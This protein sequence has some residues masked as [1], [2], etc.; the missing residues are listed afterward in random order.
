MVGRVGKWSAV[1]W[2][3]YSGQFASLRADIEGSIYFFW[4]R[5]LRPIKVA[6]SW[7]ALDGSL[8]RQFDYASEIWNIEYRLKQITFEMKVIVSELGSAVC[9]LDFYLDLDFWVFDL[10]SLVSN[11]WSLHFAADGVLPRRT[12]EGRAS[13]RRE[14]S[15]LLL[16]LL[17]F[18][19]SLLFLLDY[20][21]CAKILNC[22][23][24]EPLFHGVNNSKSA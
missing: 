23:E 1:I 4:V 8:K 6:G 14:R 18:W 17:L 2:E 5:D 22:V 20:A 19:L 10:W 15:E 11:L 13:G 7:T 16:L 9:P 21:V 12:G 24:S 3:E